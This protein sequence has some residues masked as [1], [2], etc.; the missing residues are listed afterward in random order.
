MRRLWWLF[1]LLLAGC[2]SLRDHAA[3][4]GWRFEVLKPPTISSEALVNSSGQTLGILGSCSGGVRPEVA[5]I[6]PVAPPLPL[7]AAEP[8]PIEWESLRFA[9]GAILRRLDSLERATAPTMPP[10][11]STPAPKSCP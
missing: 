4:T 6:A 3:H 2:G 5:G 10:A 11:K 9:I 8:S 7:L 1:L